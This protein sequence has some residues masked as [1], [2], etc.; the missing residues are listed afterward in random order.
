MSS[1]GLE[2]TA[3]A[4]FRSN[5]DLINGQRTGII[6]RGTDPTSTVLNGPFLDVP[7]IGFVSSSL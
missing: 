5:S 2:M 3:T 4:S 1:V 7:A 6:H